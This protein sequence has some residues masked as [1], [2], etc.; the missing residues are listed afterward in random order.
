[1]ARPVATG[2]HMLSPEVMPLFEL[3]YAPTAFRL[4]NGIFAVVKES[5]YGQDVLRKRVAASLAHDLNQFEQRPIRERVVIEGNPISDPELRVT[6]KIS[7]A[8]H[9]LVV[10]PRYQEKD[11]MIQ[12]ANQ[13]ED[14][15]SGLVVMG[16]GEQGFDMAN[17][18]R[19]SNF[20]KTYEIK[21]KF[22]RATNNFFWSGRTCEK[23]T[24]HRVNY[25]RFRQ[26]ISRTVTGHRPMIYKAMGV[27]LQSQEA[28][29]L[30]AS[31]LIRPV[32]QFAVPLLFDM[33]CT[34]FDPPDFTLVIQTANEAQYFIGTLVHGLGL[35]S[36]STACIASLKCTRYGYFT[37]ENALL[38]KQ[39]MVENVIN[40]ITAHQHLTT[41][42]KICPHK[43]QLKPMDVR[44][45]DGSE[46]LVAIESGSS[47][48]KYQLSKR[49]PVRHHTIDSLVFDD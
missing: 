40:S 10:G 14:E 27:D 11:L 42:D 4:L 45:I 18:L 7:Y 25:E 31:G 46:E 41:P 32:S 47:Q 48:P 49:E 13:V 19:Q 29:E 2:K 9:P 16:I 21:C 20:I 6:K 15:V 23:T 37:L 5:G 38:P 1:M 8:D 26:L 36:K 24:Y 35:K 28:Y 30:A 34:Y 39:W 33:Q 22:G 44:K 17:Q 3:S 12:N 43:P